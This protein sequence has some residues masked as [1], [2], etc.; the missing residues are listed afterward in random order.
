[1]DV[2]PSVPDLFVPPPCSEAVME[3][4]KIE[5]PITEDV[6]PDVVESPHP[7]NLL[8]KNVISA[9]LLI[10]KKYNL[11]VKSKKNAK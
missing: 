2:D 4:I 6:K 1:M 8:E 9:V 11:K 10:C 5:S 7:P 3:T